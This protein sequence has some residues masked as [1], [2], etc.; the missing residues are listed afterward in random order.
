ME[1]VFAYS[2]RK[3]MENWGWTFML[4]VLTTIK[5]ILLISNP[6]ISAITLPLFVGFMLLFHSI[7]A[8]ALAIDFKGYGIT[9]WGSLLF[10]GILGAVFSLFVIWKPQVGGLIIVIWTVLALIATGVLNFIM[11]LEM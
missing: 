11:S 1:I 8:I 7:W 10:I 2:N 6:A 3:I 9:G 5:G 4:G